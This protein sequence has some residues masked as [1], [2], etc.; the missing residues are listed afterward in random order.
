MG[1]YEVAEEIDLEAYRRKHKLE[2]WHDDWPYIQDGKRNPHDPYYGEST[3]EHV[4]LTCSVCGVKVE[5]KCEGG[6]AGT[7]STQPST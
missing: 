7:Q 2:P 3:H 4:W 6:Y 5:H 1:L